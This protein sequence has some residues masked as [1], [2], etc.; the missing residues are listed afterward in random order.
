MLGGKI[1]LESDQNKGTTFFFS[2]PFDN[3][4]GTKRQT[5]PKKA[6]QIQSRSQHTILA[7]EDDDASFRFIQEVL[8]RNGLNAIRAMNG[9]EAIRLTKQNPEIELVLMDIKMPVM[10]GLDATREIKQLRPEL[11]VIAE[12]AYASEEDRQKSL[13]AGCDDFIPKPIS[14]ER[15]IEL[16]HKYIQ[17][18]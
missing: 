7:V 1:W 11:P 13:D 18:S 6:E 8:N 5:K 9:E 16:I 4:R 14:K 10:N 15:L 2:L 3:A 12:T 17:P